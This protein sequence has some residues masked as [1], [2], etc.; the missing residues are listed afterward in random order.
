MSVA[1]VV[2][3][4]IVGWGTQIMLGGLGRAYADWEESFAGSMAVKWGMFDSILYQSPT[5]LCFEF[6]DAIFWELLN[7]KHDRN[8]FIEVWMTTGAPWVQT[9]S[10]VSSPATQKW[11]GMVF[12]RGTPLLVKPWLLLVLPSRAHLLE[13]SRWL[14]RS[15][16]LHAWG[17]ADV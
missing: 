17:L 15:K 6:F 12:P 11:L 2:V 16:H 8:A 13:W 5:K 10:K 9:L 1:Q 14:I 4:M 3:L 7:S